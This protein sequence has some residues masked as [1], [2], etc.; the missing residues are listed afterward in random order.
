MSIADR[1]APSERLDDAEVETGLK[2]MLRNGIC[3]QTMETLAL[4]PI[5]VA[6]A[7]HFGASN[8]SIGL[9][10]ALPQLG[11]LT[12]LPA[13]LAVERIRK[14]RLIAVLSGAMSRPAL[15]IMA[16]AAFVPSQDIA[17]A[18]IL[19]ALLLRYS[20]G[21]IVGCAWNSWIR[22]MIP[23]H[24]MG[25][26]FAN[27]MVWM[28]AVGMVVSLTAGLFVDH[29]PMLAPG[30]DV[31]AYS[32]LLCVAFAA[33]CSSIYCM[34]RMP[35]PAMPK[36]EMRVPL[37]ELLARPFRDANF[38]TLMIFL[39]AWNFAINLAAPFFTV[40]L[41]KRV[42][43][44]VTW[45]TIL[46]IVSQAANLTMLR[47]WGRIADKL[48]NK[49]VLGVAAPLFV[50]SIFLWVFVTMPEKHMLTMPLLLVIH[51]LTGISTAGVTLASGNIWLKLAPKGE[52]ASYLS[53]AT[54]TTALAAGIAP[55]IGGLFADFFA[56]RELTLI[57]RW[58]EPETRHV[59][60]ALNLR[61]W[62]FFFG[63]AAVLGLLSLHWLR[64][65]KEVGAV[66]ENIVIDELLM[67]ARQG[68]R[69]LTSVAGLRAFAGHPFELLFRRARK[70]G[71]PQPT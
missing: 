32:I 41:Y 2:W 9:L 8:L 47:T 56:D 63:G 61:H 50:L 34:S 49:A 71:P 1:L 67:S 5:L 28:T 3:A 48:S 65:I 26:I 36:V 25:A 64:A 14:R 54:L 23:E 10:A 15:L 51:I 22:D 35:E 46:M 60:Q 4:G 55:V 11:Q 27:R 62:D 31:Y 57:L 7:L 13:V 43:L 52:A 42:G 69:N 58:T 16:A 24:R 45:V 12:Q 39:A 70:S 18:M 38:K 21:S 19:V 68:M 44:S 37:R 40:Y 53:V 59:F 20:F 29:W 33:G 6:Y 66:E 30:S 17:V